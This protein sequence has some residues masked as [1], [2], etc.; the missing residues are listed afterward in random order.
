MMRL[1]DIDPTSD[2]TSVG[3]ST[4]TVDSIIINGTNIGHSDSDAISIA[5][6]GVKHFLAVVGATDTDLKLVL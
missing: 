3:T 6:S 4:L 1:Q 2:I 5:S